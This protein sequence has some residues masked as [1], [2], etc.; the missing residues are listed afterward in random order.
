[1]T[2]VG[3]SWGADL[4]SRA[5]SVCFLM[6]EG[7]TTE[8]RGNRWH[9]AS[10]WA[11]TLPVV[12]VQPV[13]TTTRALDATPEPRI[14][15][16]EILE[17][18]RAVPEP[19]YRARSAAQSRQIVRHLAHR[20]FSR[21]VLWCYNPRLAGAFAEVPAVARVFH[22]TEN[23]ADF[24]WV[25]P[26]FLTL[27]HM[28]LATSDLVVAVSAG[29]RN[30]VAP[31]VDTDRLAVVTNGCDTKQYRS[32]GPQDAELSSVAAGFDRV[33][34][35]AGY[36]NERVDY[37]LLHRAASENPRILF[38]LCG[39][40]A[41]LDAADLATWRQLRAAKNVHYFGVTDPERLPALYRTASVGLIPYKRV[42]MIIE[43]GFP[44]KTLEMCATGLPVV[45]TRMKPL[46]GLASALVV[47]PDRDAFL[48]A[49]TTTDRH[50]MT[51]AQ[52]V[53]LADL[54]ERNDYDAKF[55]EIL[56]VLDPRIDNRARPR[57][58]PLTSTFGAEGWDVPPD[59]GLLAGAR[60]I[61]ATVAAKAYSRLGEAIPRPV[62]HALP[63]SLRKWLR[64]RVAV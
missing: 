18:G 48:S 53:E 6:F 20:G 60:E 62:R 1:M 25:P 21:P 47:T 57:T 34:I 2:T 16:C 27:W 17:I 38:A 30:S 5:D 55:A 59:P 63:S 49:I 46:E 56:G 14:P 13:R 35:Y 33:A 64:N 4:T 3:D 24:E 44:L 11:Q 29:V 42:Q 58:G 45:T 12:L 43:N 50:S 61:T 52:R 31:F 32:D 7:W 22:A 37:Q 15:N 9:F 51:V 26:F 19:T 39:P 36:L 40:T 23:F 41:N 54:C 8:L 28:A 10:R